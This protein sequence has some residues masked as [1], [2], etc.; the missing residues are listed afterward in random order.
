MMVV[1]TGGG[2]DDTTY[3]GNAGNDVLVMGMY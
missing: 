3:R 1:A 2:D